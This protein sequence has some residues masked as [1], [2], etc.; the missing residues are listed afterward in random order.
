MVLNPLQHPLLGDTAFPFLSLGFVHFP[1]PPAL[2]LVTSW[3]GS[4]L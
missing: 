1:E 4:E 2:S 3:Q